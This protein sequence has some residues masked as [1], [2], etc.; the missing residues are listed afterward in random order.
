MPTQSRLLPLDGYTGLDVVPFVAADQVVAF[1]YI[2]ENSPLT[3]TL[4]EHHL[5]R[6]SAT[7]DLFSIDFELA[8]A[9]WFILKDLSRTIQLAADP[10][11]DPFSDLPG[12]LDPKLLED[13]DMPFP[14]ILTIENYT[15]NLLIVMSTRAELERLFSI[16]QRIGLAGAQWIQ[17]ARERCGADRNGYG[18]DWS[19]YG[20][21]L[22]YSGRPPKTVHCGFVEGII[23]SDEPDSDLSKAVILHPTLS[24][25]AK[26]HPDFDPF[27]L[28]NDDISN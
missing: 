28:T 25:Y 18:W 23:D 21:S 17:E 12:T 19:H 14:T 3:M 15:Q 2:L 11:L 9:L 5:H 10:L 7:E 22:T 24:N 16:A 20:N 27:I 1:Q 26:E 4:R 8:N 13:I 6:A